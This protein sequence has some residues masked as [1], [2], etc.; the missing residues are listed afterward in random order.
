MTK[1]IHPTAIVEDG[2]ILGEDVFIGPYS[3][4]GPNV[5]IG[6]GTVLKSHVFVDG[7]TDIGAMNEI[8]QF[9]SIGVPP[10]DKSYKNEKTQTI[11]GDHNLFRENCTVH[12]A[13]TKQDKKTIIGNHG[14]FMT[15]VHFAHDCVV[16]DHVTLA[17]GT[18]CAG[19]VILGDYV[20]MGGACGV[21]PFCHVGKGA[22]IGAASAIDKDIPQFCAAFG[23]RIRLKGVNIIGLRRRGYSKEVV[24]EVVEFYRMMES[25]ALSPRGFVNH[26]ENTAEY[27]GNEI[28]QEWITF[29]K[30]SEI[31]LPT[32][33]S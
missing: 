2:A 15:G 29:I 27:Q 23:N 33:M 16:G 20:Q 24:S 31:G 30:N 3:I 17:N 14:Y 10:Q 13:T 12:R 25:S 26:P 6:N 7:H 19:H 9:S 8:H 4:V 1:N 32:F 11:I 18:M 22:F 28:I 5:K 21:T